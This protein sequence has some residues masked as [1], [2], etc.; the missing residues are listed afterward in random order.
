MSLLNFQFAKKMFDGPLTDDSGQQT[1]TISTIKK[2]KKKGSTVI[3]GRDG[4]QIGE[5]LWKRGGRSKQVTLHDRTA[6]SL[7]FEQKGKWYKKNLKAFNDGAM[8]TFVWNSKGSEVRVLSLASV[9]DLIW[10]SH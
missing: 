4:V 2:G 10:L 7:L 3:Y 8:N 9:Y 6:E 5:I 1:Y